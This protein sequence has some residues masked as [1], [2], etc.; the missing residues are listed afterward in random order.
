[1][2]GK[3]HHP[4]TPASSQA[5][6]SWHSHVGEAPPQVAHAGEIQYGKVLLFGVAGAGIVVAAIVATVIYF[7]AYSDALKLKAESYPEQIH[8]LS[9]EADARAAK[10]QALSGLEVSTS[11]NVDGGFVQLSLPAARQRVVEMYKAR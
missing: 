2:S 11:V 10:A 4:A 9:M 8:K 1:M 6:D 5:S 3:H 7:N